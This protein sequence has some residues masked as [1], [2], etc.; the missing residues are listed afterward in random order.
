MHQKQQGANQVGSQVYKEISLQ[1][2]V[3]VVFKKNV[4]INTNNGGR[5]QAK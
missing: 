3:R 2:K 4:P 5:A 1:L